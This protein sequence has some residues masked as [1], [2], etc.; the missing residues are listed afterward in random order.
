[1]CNLVVSTNIWVKPNIRILRRKCLTAFLVTLN[2]SEWKSYNVTTHNTMFDS[3]HCLT[4]RHRILANKIKC[5]GFEKMPSSFAGDEAQA[6]GWW[7]DSFAFLFDYIFFWLLNFFYLVLSDGVERTYSA[8]KLCG[9]C[10]PINWVEMGYLSKKSFDMCNYIV[11]ETGLRE[12]A[13]AHSTAL[14][15][16]PLNQFYL[17]LNNF[18]FIMLF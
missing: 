17:W 5:K 10:H 9:W 8:A 2:Q 18:Y 12:N 3:L 14:R 11:P 7:Q 13:L 1:M 15:V 16:T 4:H 6:V